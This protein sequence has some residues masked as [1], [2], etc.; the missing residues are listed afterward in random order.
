M[1][2]GHHRQDL[3]SGSLYIQTPCNAT[4][5]TAMVFSTLRCHIHSYIT[6][7]HQHIMAGP[8]RHRS[9]SLT[10]HELHDPVMGSR[11]PVNTST[12]ADEELQRALRSKTPTVTHDCARL[13]ASGLPAPST[14][15]HQ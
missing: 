9:E 6:R 5:H 15:R 10:L 4:S 3:H 14:S 7:Q 13:L 1:V 12:A 11:S 2:H 8:Q